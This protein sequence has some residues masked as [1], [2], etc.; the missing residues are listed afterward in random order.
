MISETLADWDTVNA[1]DK[2]FTTNTFYTSLTEDSYRDVRSMF[3]N[4]DQNTV[5]PRNIRPNI[6]HHEVIIETQSADVVNKA[7]K[8]F[9]LVS[10]TLELFV[11]EGDKSAMLRKVWG[12][13]AG[14]YEVAAMISKR[15]ALGPGTYS[16]TGSHRGHSQANE[17]AAWYI[18]S[19]LQNSSIPSPDADP[20]FKRSIRRCKRCRSSEPF[21]S[22]EAAREHLQ[23]HI[24]R[25]S[26][27]E[28]TEE[29]TSAGPSSSSSP[30]PNLE[31]WIINYGQLKREET[32]AGIVSILTLAC[33]TAK[34]IFV[35]AKELGYGVR[36]EDGKMSDLY[37]LPRQLLEAFRETIVFYLAVERALHHSEKS[38]QEKSNPADPFDVFSLPFSE[39]G[40]DVLRRFGEGPR[41]S[42]SAARAQLCSMVASNEPLGMFGH[43]S[44]GPEYICAWLMRRLIVKPIEKTITVGDMYRDYMSAIVSSNPAISTTITKAR[45]AIPSKPPP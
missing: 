42:L 17:E 3:S 1:V 7:S 14:I 44:L 2:S 27:P 45:T 30:A 11:A 20:R 25:N 33:E 8:F 40:L 16:H 15:S 37:T 22:S 32:N 18:R 4:F 10:T 21:N 9:E 6:P 43:F 31:D 39:T 5:R 19:D 38:F 29:G 41:L 35:D 26:K 24:M 28:A 36:N 13:M 23:K 34:D 12:A